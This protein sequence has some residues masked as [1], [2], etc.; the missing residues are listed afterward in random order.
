[1]WSGDDAGSQCGAVY[2]GPAAGPAGWSCITGGNLPIFK[3]YVYVHV[4]AKLLN[5][6]CI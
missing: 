2:G 5:N 4:K 1:M 6:M 3:N